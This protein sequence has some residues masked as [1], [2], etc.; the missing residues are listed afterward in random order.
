MLKVEITLDNKPHST[1]FFDF[2][3]H[4]A[5]NEYIKLTSW[6]LKHNAILSASTAYVE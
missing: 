4:G 1:R 5:R 3:H 6:A 2:A